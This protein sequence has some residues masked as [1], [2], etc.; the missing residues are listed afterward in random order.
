[1]A[2]SLWAVRLQACQYVPRSLVVSSQKLT[3]VP[4]VFKTEAVILGLI[5]IYVGTYVLVSWYNTSQA[6]QWLSAHQP[7]LSSQFS[8][9]GQQDMMMND[10]ASDMFLFST[11]RRN[12]QSLHTIFTFIPRHDLFQLVFTYG[13]T[14]YDLRYT[15]NNDI[16][17]DFKL[18]TKG[19][20]PAGTGPSFVWAIVEKDEFK[21]IKK[22]RWDLVSYHN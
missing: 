1:M 16:T 17:L 7:V 18:G 10:G 9:P 6:K 13:W 22:A 2:N 14:L 15:P 5:L 11:G 3:L 20:A 19:R 12:I 4:K 8:S 21:N